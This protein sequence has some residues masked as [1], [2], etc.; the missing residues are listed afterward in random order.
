MLGYLSAFLLSSN[1]YGSKDAHIGFPHTKPIRLVARHHMRA[2]VSR[3][4][5]MEAT[6]RRLIAG[7]DSEPDE[8]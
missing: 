3:S 2:M 4:I 1:D 5:D 6:E 8:M 7:E